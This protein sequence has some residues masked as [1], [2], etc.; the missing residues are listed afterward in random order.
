LRAVRATAVVDVQAV[1]RALARADAVVRAVDLIGSG[2]L[3]GEATSEEES[4][5][6]GRQMD[7]VTPG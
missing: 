3:R 4:A 6:D 2:G 5:D 1:G 7:V